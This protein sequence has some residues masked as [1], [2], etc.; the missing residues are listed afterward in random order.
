MTRR[1][2]RVLAIVL[3]VAVFPIAA[4]LF[5]LATTK[6]R[7]SPIA[8]TAG[9]VVQSGDD[10][11][12]RE[13][14]RSWARKRGAINEVRLE[15]SPVDLGAANVRL[16]YD[17]QV[18]IERDLHDQF[19]HFVPY[20]AARMLIVD[21]ARVRF[22][23]LEDNLSPAHLD[24]IAAQ[25]EAFSPDPFT[26]LMDTYQ[27]F[28]FL[29]SLYDIMLSFERSPLVGCTSFVLGGA[30]TADGHTLVGRNFDFEGPQVLDDRK[31]VF[32]VLEDGAIP[33]ASVSWP[34][35]IGAASGM[36]YEGLAIVIH[37]AR[38]GE[39]RETGEPV[40]QTVR[41][42]L[43]RA[44]TTREAVAMLSRRDPMVSH[45]LLIADASGD[46]VVVERVPGMAPFVRSAAGPRLPL[47]NHL[48][49]PFADD[50]KNHDVMRMTSTLPRRRRLDELL[51][52]VPRVATVQD[53]LSILRDKR[54][55]DNQLL[56]LGHRSA[57]DALISTHTI[58]MDTT[59]RVLWVGEGPHATGR[60]VRFDLGELLDPGYRPQ[61][62]ARVETLPQD[63][64]VRDG[65]YDAWVRAG[66]PHAGAE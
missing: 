41:D 51:S 34:G 32:L 42:L 23:N 61:G 38:A 16:L 37:G 56:P 59:A 31:A 26:G 36:N 43:S 64:I 35:F 55:T 39:P 50:P 45:M 29:H 66:S 17:E 48:E 10:P 63:D 60:F 6:M 13:L 22:R 15:G 18:A 65:Q 57:I 47:T 20:A 49:G 12:R 44:R 40:A 19:S 52:N 4:H 11:T 53:A 24:E 8:L 28:V 3:A 46:A 27:R 54:S 58:V 25:A 14:G 21:M 9:E 33:Y 2:R 1:R 7:P 62:P 5:V 30:T